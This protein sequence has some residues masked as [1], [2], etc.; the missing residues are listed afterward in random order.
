MAGLPAVLMAD[1]VPIPVL[2]SRFQLFNSGN[3]VP[4]IHNGAHQPRR[5]TQRTGVGWMRGLGGPFGLLKDKS[6]V[7]KG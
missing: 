5:E 6:K 2:L 7:A 3:N 4:Q 1:L